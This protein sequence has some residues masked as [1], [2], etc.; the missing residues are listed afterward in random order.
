MINS[1]AYRV[2]EPSKSAN[3][4]ELRPFAAGIRPAV[5]KQTKPGYINR[6]DIYNEN[7]ET[8]VL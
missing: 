1:E 8:V 3:I 4:Y 6:K 5:N 2:K 7:I